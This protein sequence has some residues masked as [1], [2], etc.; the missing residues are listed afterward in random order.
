V[1][2]VFIIR[3][4]LVVL[5]LDE[6]RVH[7]VGVEG[8]RDESVDSGRLGDD[9]ERPRLCMLVMALARRRVFLTYLL[10]L[11]LN[12]V[13]VVLNDLVALVLARLE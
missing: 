4:V 13:S 9:L 11:E 5:D 2:V 12:Q 8:Q 3:L 6:V 7:S 10:I 1:R